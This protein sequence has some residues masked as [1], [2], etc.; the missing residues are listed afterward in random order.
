MLLRMQMLGTSITHEAHLSV[1]G[2]DLNPASHA[3][4]LQD[5]GAQRLLGAE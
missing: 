1:V 4:T 2:W 5:F 3:P